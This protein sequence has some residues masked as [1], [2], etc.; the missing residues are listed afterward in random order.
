MMTSYRDIGFV[1]TR[2][3]FESACREGYAVPAYNFAALEQLQ[4]AV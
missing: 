1:N 4:A 2:A 3:M